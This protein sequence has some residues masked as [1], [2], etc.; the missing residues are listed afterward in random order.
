MRITDSSF[1]WHIP[2]FGDISYL[3]IVCLIQFV[4]NSWSS[5]DVMI[6]N[7]ANNGRWPVITSHF[8]FTSHLSAYLLVNISY[9]I[10]EWKL[11]KITFG[12]PLCK[13]TFASW[14]NY[15]A[16]CIF[17][18]L[19]SQIPLFSIK[20]GL[21]QLLRPLQIQF[22]YFSHDQQMRLAKNIV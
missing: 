19:T 10:C 5:I 21:R 4:L 2:H 17:C 8:F 9:L 12:I 3:L 22:T 18:K 15:K 7:H 14:K 20:K 11:L 13:K 1:A 16:H 6:N